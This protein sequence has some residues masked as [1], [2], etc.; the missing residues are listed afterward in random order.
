MDPPLARTDFA[1]RAP[2]GCG[3]AVTDGRRLRVDTGSCAP[4]VIVGQ[5]QPDRKIK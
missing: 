1:G 2:I 3:K 4:I 5:M